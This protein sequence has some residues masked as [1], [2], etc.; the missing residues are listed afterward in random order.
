MEALRW[1]A[2]ELSAQT[3]VPPC[4]FVA[5]WAHSLAAEATSMET[6]GVSAGRLLVGALSAETAE[7]LGAFA[8]V[9]CWLVH[10]SA[11][12]LLVGAFATMQSLAAGATSAEAP[13]FSAGQLLAGGLSAETAIPLRA[14]ESARL[15]AL[16]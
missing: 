5:A 8:A 7:P 12:R 2:G 11:G 10:C 6:L 1:S 9:D 4:G 15:E 14:F 3:A 16:G 13:G